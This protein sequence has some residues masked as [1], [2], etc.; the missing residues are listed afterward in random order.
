[1]EP[2]RLGV[3]GTGGFARYHL[4]NFEN[5]SGVEIVGFAEPS[6]QQVAETKRRF[7]QWSQAL[8]TEDY[9]S[10]LDQAKLDAVLISSPHTLHAQQILD[11]FDAG[12]HVLCDKPLVTTVA[13]AHAVIEAR[14]RTGRIGMVSYQRHN[15][16]LYRLVRDRIISGQAGPVQMI[17]AYLTQEWKRLTKGSWRQDP[18]LSG[19]GQLNDSGSH[20][21]DILLWMTDLSARSVCCLLDHRE[22]PVDIN[23]T[24]IVEF[25]QGALGSLCVAGDAHQWHEDISVI[26]DRQTFHIRAG[27]LTVIEEDGTMATYDRIH[28][29]STPERNFI[30]AI[31]GR[32]DVQAPFECGLRVIELTEAAWRSAA[33]GG[34]PIQ[35]HA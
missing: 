17:Q 24:V 27:K 5:V 18:A 14:D 20:M 1:M 2:V 13:D 33:E 34:K 31:H 7:P 28:G 21:V 6:P 29:G 15:E 11:S 12:C 22:T 23:S 32:E 16:A 9:R 35:V 4:S 3:I 30:E 19:G 8:F 10:L 25:D 26:C